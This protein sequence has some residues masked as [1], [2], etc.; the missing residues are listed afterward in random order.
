[1][2]ELLSFLST[3]LIC[4]WPVCS[5]YHFYGNMLIYLVSAM[6]L[7]YEVYDQCTILTLMKL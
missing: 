2:K 1:M 3:V 6:S 7:N 4:S 5:G